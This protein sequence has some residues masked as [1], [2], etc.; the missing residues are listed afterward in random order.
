MSYT[1]AYYK[2]KLLSSLAFLERCRDSDTIPSFVEVK[3][4]IQSKKA[5]RILRRASTAL[6]RERVQHT[7]WTIQTRTE[8]LYELHLRLSAVLNITDWDTLDRITWNSATTAFVSTRDKQV[9]KYERLHGLQHPGLESHGPEKDRTVVNLTDI[10]LSDAAISVLS[11][12][13]NF[14]VAPARLPKEELVT[15]VEYAVRKLPKEEA[16]ELRGEVSRI[17]LNAKTPKPNVTREERKALRDLRTNDDIIITPADKGNAMVLMKKDDYN[18]KINSLLND[19]TYSEEK[20]DPTSRIQKEIK[21]IITQSSI[22]PEERRWIVESAPKPP[23]LYG[24]PKI[25]KPGVPL[26]PINNMQRNPMGQ[27][28]KRDW[29]LRDYS[30]RCLEHLGS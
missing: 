17:L 16:E 24:L 8:E 1:P 15:E 25:H 30:N 4:H 28:G 10:H 26:R 9:K 12:G 5:L 29:N 19:E 21:Q 22:P 2:D 7:R 6:L 3:H 18:R 23:R 14:A 27:S 13:L 11:K 20:R